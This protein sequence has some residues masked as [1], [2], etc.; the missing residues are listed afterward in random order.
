MAVSVARGELR[1]REGAESGVHVRVEEHG[2]GSEVAVDHLLLPLLV[3]AENGGG[4]ALDDV[5]TVAPR[6]GHVA[7]ERWWLRRPGVE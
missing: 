6:Q 7:V 3:Q 2:G 4:E 5:V 1:E